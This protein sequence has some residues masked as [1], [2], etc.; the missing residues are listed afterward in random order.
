MMGPSKSGIT[1][2]PFGDSVA[3]PVAWSGVPGSEEGVLFINADLNNT[4]T[5]GFA[6][7]ITL[8]GLNTIPLPPNGTITLPA[9]RSVYAIAPKGTA[10]L[11]IIPGGG[12]YFQGLTQGSGQLVLPSVRSPNF[13]H[14]VSGWIIS[15]DGSAEF[16]NLVIR[17][18][19]NGN[20]F[21]INSLGEFFYSGTPALGNLIAS[22]ASA[23]G[24][25]DGLGNAFVQGLASYFIIS[26][27]QLFATALQGANIA[28]FF[29]TSAGGPWN[30]MGSIAQGFHDFATQT[31]PFLQSNLP[32]VIGSNIFETTAKLEI[33]GT[34]A[35]DS[36]DY[37]PPATA[38]PAPPT[39]VEKWNYVGQTGQPVFGAGWTN[40]GGGFA[41]LGFRFVTSPP[42]S[43]QIYGMVTHTAVAAQTMFTLPVAYR[44]VSSQQFSAVTSTGASVG[45]EVSNGG[46]VE[47]Q[48]APGA[49]ITLNV[50][51]LV[52]LDI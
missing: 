32:F 3:N 49:L 31:F 34:A 33:Q 47:L 44:P 29:A 4:V 51:L 8:N 48:V 46:L 41:N 52:S 26:P 23:G 16:N 6:P 36:L 40:V 7:Q 11:I 1:Q 39:G 25:D 28:F 45:W 17:G 15:K 10:N 50:D 43:V 38:P 22:N 13:D 21:V 12:A 27:T 19:F 5:L 37:I 42:R 2:Y 14:G 35:A 9:D 24:P 20:D 18:V 30:A